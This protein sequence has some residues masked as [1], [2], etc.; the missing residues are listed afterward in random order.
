MYHRITYLILLALLTFGQRVV[1]QNDVLYWY[2]NDT[3]HLRWIPAS[4]KGLEGY[5]V[6]RKG[7]GETSW[8]TLN[9][10][11]IKH[12]TNRAE[13]EKQLGHQASLYWSFFKV[14]DQSNTLSDDQYA[15]AMTDKKTASFIG[16]M[17]LVNPKIGEA[18]GVVHHDSKPDG[19]VVE[20]K[21]QKV[22]NGVRTDHAS[23]SSINLKESE[24]VP[25][26]TGFIAGSGHERARLEW[27]KN[28]KSL[29]S[30]QI[31]TY[32]VYRSTS[33]LGP[34][35]RVNP[36]GILPV[37]ITSGKTKSSANTQNY[38][39]DYLVNGQTY[40][41]QIRNVNAF[42]YESEPSVTLSVTPSDNRA[43][44]APNQVS[45]DRYGNRLAL[46]WNGSDSS[47]FRI[48]R[49]TYDQGAFLRTVPAA[50]NLTYR[51][52]RWVDYSAEP[53]NVY[54]YVVQSV[55]PDG[56]GTS[57][58]DT[59]RFVFTDLN[60]PNP[61]TK[62]VATA[63]DGK[64]V[65]NWTASSTQTVIGYE[66]ERASDDQFN[67][68]FSLNS[69][70][71][72]GTT[73]TDDPEDRSSRKYGYVIYAVNEA[74]IRSQPSEM[75]KAN[76][77]DIDPP[78]AP[79][80]TYLNQVDDSI[81]IVWTKSSNDVSTYWVERSAKTKSGWVSVGQT[82]STKHADRPDKDGMY[83]YRITA[84][85]SSKN[86][87]T[88]SQ[89]V[90]VDFVRIARTP[91]PIKFSAAQQENNDVVLSWQLPGGA[92]VNGFVIYRDAGSNATRIL[93]KEV[94]GKT[95]TLTDYYTKQNVSYRYYIRAYD[96]GGRESSEVSI[97]YQ[98]RK[99]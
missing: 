9:E 23:L 27:N 21:I 77:P 95:F 71:I 6:M 55:S 85:D 99:K 64:I 82:S 19:E 5:H 61:P 92:E 57:N 1:A 42:G 13:V 14:D 93:V 26:P 12:Q 89:L 29:S 24:S 48:W 94:N 25:V 69:T 47:T 83:N 10:Q 37:T 91:A 44:V 45:V 87:S 60:A 97:S 80:I 54:Q 15:A 16:A 66:I 79:V 70:V 86:R 20:Y 18:L 75:A 78:S 3:L 30:G 36:Q 33:V 51:E 8:K 41:Y 50:D 31:V 34:F 90:P 22:V 68:R 2:H 53:G 4:D 62:V 76:L 63:K 43:P 88:P 84:M 74:G 65:L 38:V 56:T 52:N 28:T 46:S 72:K 58:S 11:P 39:D 98:P 40:Y 35:Q 73:F 59:V 49:R 32:M 81:Q 17:S 7:N 67:T 96:S